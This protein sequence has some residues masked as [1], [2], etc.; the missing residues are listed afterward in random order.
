M[1]LMF[2]YVQI[3]AL[4]ALAEA[5]LKGNAGLAQD[6]D[7]GVL[8]NEI[9][10]ALFDEN[11]QEAGLKYKTKYRAI[12]FNLKDPRNNVLYKY[13]AGENSVTIASIVRFCFVCLERTSG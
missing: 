6:T 9:E 3:I 13:G 1:F 12:Y 8:A 7:C 5:R 11:N 10:Q 2:V 4:Y